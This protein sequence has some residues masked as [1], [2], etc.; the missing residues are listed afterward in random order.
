MYR[1]LILLL[2]LVL[3]LPLLA[4][5]KR[6]VSRIEVVG[7]V[8]DHIVTS[9]SAL[10]AGRSYSDRDLEIAVARVRRLPFVYDVRYSLDGETLVIE[11]TAVSQFS[12]DVDAAGSRFDHEE[13]GNADVTGVGRLFVG[14]GGVA[15]G[16]A[17][18]VLSDG[19]SVGL[20][21]A[22]YSQYGIGGTRFFATAGL[23]YGF[24]R[25]DRIDADPTWRLTV[26]YPLTLRQTLRATAVG[27]GFNSR[28]TIPILN[29]RTLDS[30]LDRETLGL[31]WTFDTTE[32]PFFAR[33]GERVNV[34]PSWANE[35][36]LFHGL[37]IFA[38][39]GPVDVITTATDGTITTFGADATKY[40]SVG[41]RGAI[42][43]SVA[44]S[45]ESR[46]IDYRVGGT[47]QQRADVETTTTVLSLGYAHNLFD[48]GAPVTATRQRLEFGV[49][50]SR[51]E[52]DRP[53]FSNGRIDEISLTT[54]Y[55]LRKQFATIRLN[56]SYTFTNFN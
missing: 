5:T 29:D 50:A 48:Q 38:P 17:G 53:S 37:A 56:L 15:R 7:D 4:Q 18:G 44:A 14:S 26:G 46:D 12:A 31:Q 35:S 30:F 19:D 9:Q 36:S 28:R 8:P 39:D 16:R 33:T 13:R 41:S 23:S 54:G 55:A 51:R 20:V 6:L 42:F 11:V 52:I 10:V 49:A 21:D 3:A 22:E 1:R 32:D 43:S 27:E 34:A 40:W 47:A 45:L 24:H 25:D 2:I